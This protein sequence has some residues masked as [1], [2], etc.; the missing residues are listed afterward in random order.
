MRLL[1]DTHA[2]LWF[3][4]ERWQIEPGS[5]LNYFGLYQ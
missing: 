2:L 3:V 1:L 5:G 4:F